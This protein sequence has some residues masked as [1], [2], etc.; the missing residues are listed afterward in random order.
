MLKETNLNG[1]KGIAKLITK[2]YGLIFMHKVRNYLSEKEYAWMLRHLW[3]R[4]EYPNCDVNVTRLQ[5]VD[6]F[7][8]ANPRWLMDDAEEFQRFMDLP[9]TLT[10]YRG[11]TSYNA[12]NIRALSWTLSLDTARWF[13]KRFGERGTVYH[14][15]ADP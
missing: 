6:M 5:L 9:D 15:D 2:P 13:A 4:S 12:D 14:Y 3:I 11:V 10:V 1:V 7:R 8:R